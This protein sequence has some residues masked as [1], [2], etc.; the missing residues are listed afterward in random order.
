MWR[1]EVFPVSR[2]GNSGLRG[3]T[4][5]E[6]GSVFLQ[7]ARI[8][9]NFVLWE[10]LDSVSKKVLPSSDAPY[11]VV[12]LIYIDDPLRDLFAGRPIEQSPDTPRSLARVVQWVDKCNAEHPDCTTSPPSL[13]ARVIDVG[14]ESSGYCVKLCEMNCGESGNYITLS[15]CWGTVTQF[16]TTKA[17]IRAHTN[18]IMYDE[19]PKSFRDAIAITR[20]LGVR[21]IWI[22]SICICQDDGKD[23]ERE[24][25]NMTNI[26]MNSY[27]TLAASA[28]RDSSIGCFLPRNPTRYAEIPFT[29]QGG[30]SGNIQAF[31][32]PVRKEY[33][34]NLYIS[35]ADHIEMPDHPL[36]TRAWAVQERY[37]PRRT[38]HFG[39]H[40]MYFECGKTFGGEN[41]LNVSWRYDSVHSHPDKG[42]N[43]E[44][45]GNKG[46]LPLSQWQSLLWD[47]GTRKLT[48]P[49]DKLPAISGIAR[50]FAESLDDEYV[51][52][53]WSKSLIEGLYW[54]GLSVHRVP[55]YRAPSWSWAS[56]DGIPASGSFDRCAQWE[57]VAEILEY[58]VDLKGKNIFGEVTNGW[59]KLKAPL[60]PLTLDP[61]IDPE[62]DGIHYSVNPK[63]WTEDWKGE[64]G[65]TYSR[66]DFDFTGPDRR[67]DAHAMVKSL[68]GVPIFALILASMKWDESD[69]TVFYPS[70]IVRY[71]EGDNSAMQRLGFVDFDNNELGE[72]IQL[73]HAE[74]RHVI[75]L[76]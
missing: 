28:A 63:I 15:H 54:Q 26:Y 58:K 21:Y 52:G 69:E 55:T 76:V 68:E 20:L 48:R 33:Y 18:K 36:L 24:S 71:A 59:I 47:Y 37:L 53:L 75:K 60:L 39:K 12:I 73:E 5:L 38:L 2:R 22:D 70:L 62:N 29:T 50:L 4:V 34:P 6:M 10:L 30:I 3:G 42:R 7:T 51:A 27:L 72:C 49:S 8:A 74:E 45:L 13:P 17:S 57:P 44:V 46:K 67:E 25:A 23:W 1:L 9:R 40:Q 56:V 16:T 14:D 19:L 41:G 65:G 35:M 66:F 61:R 31:I 11:Q 64:P 32:L 43:G